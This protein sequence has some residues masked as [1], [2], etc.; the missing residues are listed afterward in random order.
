[1]VTLQAHGAV[2][3]PEPVLQTEAE[4]KALVK[5]ACRLG[6]GLRRQVD[7]EDQY[8]VGAA[9]LFFRRLMILLHSAGST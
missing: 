5:E 2:V 4:I 7:V 8:L 9:V 6:A 3:L 1:M